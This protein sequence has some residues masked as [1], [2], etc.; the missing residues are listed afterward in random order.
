MANISLG[1]IIEAI[2]TGDDEGLKALLNSRSCTPKLLNGLYHDGQ[3][4]LNWAVSRGSVDHVELL[5]RH[6]ADVNS[7][8]SA[9]F[10]ALVKSMSD[11]NFEVFKSLIQL[12]ANINVLFL[13]RGG[14]T[15]LM[16]ACRRNYGLFAQ[17]LLQRGVELNTRDNDGKT[18]LYLASSRGHT[19]CVRLLLE[20]GADPEVRSMHGRTA[21][22]TASLN[23]RYD[24]V[25]LLLQYGADSSV[26][27][28]FKKSALD[29]AETKNI[30]TAIQDYS[31]MEYVLK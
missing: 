7:L 5:V 18:A 28:D 31:D 17:E 10:S 6:G 14:V 4:A 2:K 23:N 20:Y 12:N 8:D 16:W 27:D 22:I 24:T 15:P 21:L 11:Q 3:T 26:I 9:G 19:E 25:K 30:I 1:D 13:E 29:Y